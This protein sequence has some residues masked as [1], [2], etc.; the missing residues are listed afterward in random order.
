MPSPVRPTPLGFTVLSSLRSSL[1]LASLSASG[2]LLACDPPCE[3]LATRICE[4]EAYIQEQ[5]ACEQTIEVNQSLRTPTDEEN[6][7]CS[8]LLDTC[9][10]D[11]LEREDY[12]ACGLTQG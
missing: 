9:D 5:T 3:A 10:C 8:E 11:A 6:E 2:A 7:R 1:L 12:V 4:C